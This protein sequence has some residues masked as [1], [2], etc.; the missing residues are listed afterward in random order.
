MR[1]VPVPLGKKRPALSL[2]RVAA[3]RLPCATRAGDLVFLMT[4][5]PRFKVTSRPHSGQVKVVFGRA[6]LVLRALLGGI[7][8]TFL[9]FL[10][11]VSRR[12]YLFVTRP[13]ADDH[14]LAAL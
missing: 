9:D 14:L 7:Q 11:V 6:L 2:P 13:F 8:L 10:G 1:L 3:R 12:L 4:A 5:L